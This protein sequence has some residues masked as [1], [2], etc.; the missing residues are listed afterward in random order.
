MWC[1]V[2]GV[3]YNKRM[4]KIDEKKLEEICRKYKV[5]FLGIFGSAARGK[6]RPGSDVDVLVRFGVGSEVGF[7]ELVEME[8]E[9]SAGIKKKVDLVTEGALSPYIKDRVMADL[10]PLY[11][12][13]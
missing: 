5:D 6:M 9:L 12:S 1:G 10:K 11:G 7:F 13:L 4:V 8:N 3:W 2:F